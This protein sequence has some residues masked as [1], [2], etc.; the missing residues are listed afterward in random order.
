MRK[1]SLLVLGVVLPLTMYSQNVKMDW[2]TDLDY[3]AKVLPTKH[4]N[5]F[6]V[7]SSKDFLSGINA[8]K[9][10]SKNLNDFQIALKAQQLIAKFGDSHTMLNFNRLLNANQI[11]PISLFWASD[12]LYILHT[13]LENEKILGS[14]VLSINNVPLTV[15]IDSLS[16]LFAV[17]NQATVKSLIP[18]TIPSLQILEYFGFANTEQVELGLNQN[19]TYILKPSQMN[20]NNSVSVKPDSLAFSTRNESQV[21][22]DF[23]YPN[24]KIY[25]MQYNKCLS[26]EVALAYGN[27]QMADKLPSFK[28]FEEKAFSILSTESIEKIVFDMRYNGGGNSAQGTAFIERLSKFLKANPT[29][30]TYVVLGR[31]TFSSAIINAMDFKRM[32]HAIFVGEETSG[33]PNHFG[34]V[35]NFQLPTSQLTV[36]Y[37]TKYFKYNKKDVSTLVPD[38]KIEMSFSDLMKG[39]DPIYE[40]IKQQ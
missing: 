24:E 2:N 19:R 23:Y 4:Y 3:L 1:I 29:I 36:N 17:D 16:T 5:F 34:E 18:K 40:W 15:V 22:T 12:G 21:F 27:N 26:K 28:E 25:Y 13:T 7:R 35:K 9:K 10:E 14:K 30:K 31:A 32:T 33:K 38:V 8:I 37:S 39:I 20:R 6:T 11:L